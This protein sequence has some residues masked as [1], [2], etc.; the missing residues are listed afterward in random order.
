[1]KSFDAIVVGAGPAGITAALKMAQKGLRVILLER[2]E[3]PGSKNMFGGMIPGSPVF[4]ELIPDFWDHAPWERYVVRRELT[5]LSEHASTSFSFETMN[6][7]RPPYNGYT[8]YRPVFDKWYAEQARKAGA[9]LIT[10][11]LVEDLL[12]E[13][14]SI[15]GVRVG[16]DQGDIR[17]KV[18]VACDGA[19]SLLAKK[20]GLRRDFNLSQMGVGIRALFRLPEEE[21]NQRFNLVRQQGVAKAFLGCTEGIRGGGF[22]YTQ[23][24]TL[25]VGL[26]FH[27]QS[28]KEKKIP[29]YE[30]LERFIRRDPVRQ[31][32]KGSRL[33]DFSAHLI[34]EGGWSMVPKLS[35]N[36]L[37]VAGDAAALCY[38]DGLNQEGMN[39]AAASGSLAAETVIEAFSR[40]DFSGKQMARYDERLRGSF[41]LKNMKTARKICDFMHNDRLF[42]LYPEV[43]GNVMEQIY[44][45]DGNSR[46]GFGHIAWNAIRKGVP[47][48]Q[49]LADFWNGGRSLI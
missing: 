21:I 38:T 9:Q 25:S 5:V 1:M 23:T 39:L 42:S 16:R 37:L 28:L 41:V 40:G 46:R 4:N 15:A 18:V 48:P 17:A 6:F 33:L 43:I 36:G 27:L 30:L 20:A 24:D 7:D 14:S 11:C 31:F 10:G 26:V 19:L 47:L 29:P 12:W 22:I 32:I 44:L 45:A 49:L 35:M 8:L 2:G 13:E 3:F 34:P